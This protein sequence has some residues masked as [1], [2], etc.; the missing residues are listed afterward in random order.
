MIE[1]R[2]VEITPADVPNIA[3]VLCIC[4]PRGGGAVSVIANQ[5]GRDCL[6]R[7]FPT[8]DIPWER[9]VTGFPGDWLQAIFD[10]PRLAHG[11]HN[12]PPITGN[13]VL[14]EATPKALT[15]LIAIAAKYQGARAMLWDEESDPPFEL[16]VPP[17][18]NN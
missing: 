2:D 18:G 1:T 13:A 8:W 14:E 6:H 15:F 9:N 12:L 5:L 7:I 16:Y 4:E 10:V 17:R 11:T 3:D